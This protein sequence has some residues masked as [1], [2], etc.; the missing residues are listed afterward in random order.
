[1]ED[2]GRRMEA[3]TVSDMEDNGRR[4]E[5]GPVSDMENTSRR[6]E[7]GTVSAMENDGRRTEAGALRNR[8]DDGRRTEEAAFAMRGPQSE[9]APPRAQ[10]AASQPPHGAPPHEPARGRS[11]EPLFT[12]GF[13][14]IAIAQAFSLLGMEILQFVLPLHLLN[15]TGSGTLYGTVLAAGFIPYTLLAPIGGVVADRTRKRGV[16][17]AL[18]ALLALVMAAYLACSGSDALVAITVAVLMFA[19]AAQALYQPCVQSAVP[20]VV[21]PARLEQA[22]AV[23][24]QLSMVTGIGGPVV[25]GLVFGFCGLAPIAA[26]SAACFAVSSLLVLAIVRVPYDPPARTAGLLATAR[27]DLSEALGH[28]RSHPIMWQT[29]LGATLVNLFGS[30]FIN[31]GSP[32]IVTESL[33]L[34]NQLMGVLQGALAVGGL[35][36]GA[37]VAT[38]PGSFGI[39]SVPRLLVGVA[40]GLAAMAVLLTLPLPPLGVYAGMLAIYL[41][42]MACCMAMSI[43][44]TSYL[45][46]ESPGTLVG[47]VMALTLMLANFATPLGQIAYGAAFDRVDPWLVAALAALAVALVT[48]HLARV[49]RREL[50]R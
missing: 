29:I 30:S 46:M 36:G 3:G 41:G 6:T 14:A 28:L 47:K 49:Y 44:A 4:M 38:R 23:T 50:S 24:N 8:G 5:A 21:A 25:G 31:V 15:L 9:D 16:M 42:T 37:L 26:V 7:A 48:A 43:A 12:P 20:H 1:M 40:A 45:Q 22:V 11:D 32:Y 35:A 18:D 10:V 39:R 33:G 2:N 34:S 13:A 27:A 17:A 19:F